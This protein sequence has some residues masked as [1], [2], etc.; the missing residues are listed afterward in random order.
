MKIAFVVH[1]F[2]SLSETFILNQIVGLIQEGHD[3]DIYAEESEV[4]DKIHPDVNKYNLTSRTY[5]QPKIPRNFLLRVAK[6]VVILLRYLF[7]CPFALFR[8][9]NF[10]AYGR[11][12][13]SLRLL[14][15]IVP[16]IESRTKRYDIMHCHFGN[17]GV[18]GVFTREVLKLTAK[19][20]TT[21]YGYD[22]N[23]Y[24][25]TY[26]K[27]VYLPLFKRGDHYIAISNFIGKEAISLG[28]PEAKLIKI[29]LGLD[30]AEYHF[31]PRSLPEG[32]L[33]KIVTVARLVEKKGI[34]YSIQAVAEVAKKY[35]HIQYCI[36]GDG[37]LRA[38]LEQLIKTLKVEDKVKL[39]GWKTKDEVQQLYDDSHIFILAS[40]TA[41]NGDKEGQGLVLQEAQSMGL[42]VIAT[43]HNGFPDSIRDGTSGFLVPERD[44]PSLAHKLIYLV[45]NPEVWSEMGHAGRTFVEEVFDNQKLT[46]KLIHVYQLVLDSELEP[47]RTLA[48]QGTQ[49]PTANS[50]Q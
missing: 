5:Y 17:E 47:S 48:C 26:G 39:L 24:P 25:L 34:E 31:R 9:L 20:V 33:I 35:P 7:I 27:N 22:V 11:Q 38:S 1:T 45:E 41:A 3:V 44:I 4:S 15:A 37:P 13:S 36:A 29:P 6:A 32:E 50:Q 43:I 10:V 8:C 21:F 46:Q 40:V 23:A 28:C 14:Y 30:P 42:P 19:V 49:Q 16:F 18:R 12:A 2:P